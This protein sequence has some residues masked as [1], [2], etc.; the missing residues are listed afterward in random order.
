MFWRKKKAKAYCALT[1]S[2]YYSVMDGKNVRLLWLYYG[3][4]V[5]Q[6]C[7]NYQLVSVL[8]DIFYAVSIFGL[9]FRQNTQNLLDVSNDKTKFP[10]SI[11]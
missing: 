5:L 9:S 6:L 11:F 2:F 7:L 3:M 1:L 4:Y 8:F 10:F